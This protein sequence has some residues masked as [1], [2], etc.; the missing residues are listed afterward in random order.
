MLL[1]VK[2]KTIYSRLPYDLLSINV[3]EDCDLFENHDY[4]SDA[5]LMKESLQIY[6]RS[7]LNKLDRRKKDILQRYFGIGCQSETL[8]EIG[9]S[10]HLTRERARQILWKSIKII[11][12]M[13]GIRGRKGIE[14]V[15]ENERTQI[16]KEIKRNK[17][18][19][20]TSLHTK[21]L[22]EVKVHSRRELILSA[23]ESL[24]DIERLNKTFGTLPTHKDAETSISH[25]E[26]IKQAINAED[27]EKSKKGTTD[28]LET[29]FATYSQRILNLRPAKRNGEVIV[30][31]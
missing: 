9:K 27:K 21:R 22:E 15:E 3:Y 4:D 18:S 14:D 6:I 16:V 23:K 28:K 12:V 13:L 2:D 20:D 1:G 30:G 25:Q 26:P 19:V 24:I 17:V 31:Y 10:Y 7:L 5:S 11:K 8:E 29:S